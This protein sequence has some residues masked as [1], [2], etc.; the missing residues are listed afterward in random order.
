MP[1]TEHRAALRALLALATPLLLTELTYAVG[2]TTDLVMVARLGTSAVGALALANGVIALFAITVAPFTVYRV[3][4][5]RAHGA[6]G[7]DVRSV[8][9]H[10]FILAALMATIVVAGYIEADRILAAIGGLFPGRAGPS[11]L[12]AEAG[13]YCRVVAL[14]IP[15]L[16]TQYVLTFLLGGLSRPTP[17]LVFTA[18]IILLNGVFDWVFIFGKLGF[19]ALGLLGSAWA[20]NAARAVH[21]TILVGYVARRG[22]LPEHPEPIRFRREV[23]TEMLTGG[24]RLLWTTLAEQGSAFVLTAW[25][26]RL[27]P[28]SVAGHE[29]SRTLFVTASAVPSSLGQANTVIIARRFAAGEPGP[30]RRAVATAMFA[31]GVYAV[32]AAVVLAVG[33]GYLPGLYTSDPAAGAIAQGVLP[34]AALALFMAAF[35]L[36]A[37]AVLVALLDI[38]AQ[39]RR[40]VICAWLIKL[41][42]ASIL[43]LAAG[44]GVRAAWIAQAVSEAVLVALLAVRV[45]TTLS[46]HD[47]AR[48]PQPGADRHRERQE[49]HRDLDRQV[50]GEQPDRGR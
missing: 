15:L 48:P 18:I 3:M 20:T 2:S 35:R 11:E 43:L 8:F 7:A 6:G 37:T 21:L 27:G 4:V 1:L 31:A 45:R 41:P 12:V 40:V 34:I 13:A 30:L 22:R 26:G 5:A 25:I 49:Q 29:V 9:I 38:R 33:A 32:V 28:A 10:G 44:L 14:G 39:M 23:L 36:T 19:P 47:A 17:N 16:Y 46:A 50:I 24:L 42:L